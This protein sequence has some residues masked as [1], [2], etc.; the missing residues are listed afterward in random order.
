MTWVSWKVTSIKWINEQMNAHPEMDREALRKHCSKNYP[1]AQRSG[2]AYKS[3]LAAMKEVFG[4]RA[5]K[6]RDERIGQS[7]MFNAPPHE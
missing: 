5:R 6:K 1:Y 3:F 2:W 7:D 4:D